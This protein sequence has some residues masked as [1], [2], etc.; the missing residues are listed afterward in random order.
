LSWNGKNQKLHGGS[1]NNIDNFWEEKNVF[2]TGCTGFLGYWLTDTLQKKGAHVVGLVRDYVPHADFFTKDLDKKVVTVTGSLEEFALLERIVNEYEID[3]VFHLGAQTQVGV[4]NRSP[5]A[6]FETNIKGT[7][8]LLEACRVN[9]EIVK[10]IVVASS[11]KAYGEQKQLPYTEDAP[12]K[13]SHPYDVSKSCTDLITSTYYHTYRMPVGITRCGNI[14]GPGDLNYNR[15]IPGTIKAVMLDEPIIIRSDGTLIRDYFYVKDAVNAYITLA[16]NL[17][18]P[19]VVG[20]AFN[21]SS[22]DPINVLEMTKKIADIMGK[23]D[24]PITI[25]NE[26]KG[27][28]KDQYL[29]NEKA[30]RILQWQPQYTLEQ[31]LKETIETLRG[32]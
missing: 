5:L 14:F 21:F 12:L 3:T 29:S 18:K 7:W 1:G 9:R 13:G 26:A 31:A 22:G 24:H 32:D 10:R 17:E 6:T 20:G 4:G 28:I 11:D 30:E 8:N 27:E 25:L 19:N 23:P 2:V 16:Q 15:L